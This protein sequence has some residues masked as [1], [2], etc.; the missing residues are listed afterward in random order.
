VFTGLQRIQKFTYVP[1]VSRPQLEVSPWAGAV[2][3]VQDV[4]NSGM[5]ERAW[6]FH[7]NPEN[8]HVLLCGNPA[9]IESM[10]AILAAAGFQRETAR[11]PGQVHCEKFWTKTTNHLG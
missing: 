7:A 5:L 10:L 8:S 9:M 6:G 3:Q 4:W 2:G 1:V 11:A